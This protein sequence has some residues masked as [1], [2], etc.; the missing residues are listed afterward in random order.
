MG[1]LAHAIDDAKKTL[2]IKTNA[3]LAERLECSDNEISRAKRTSVC[4]DRLL[5][6]LATISGINFQILWLAREIDRAENQDVKSE[7]CKIAQQ[8]CPE[9]FIT[10]KF[11]CAVRQYLNK[12]SK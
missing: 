1:M 3:V 8:V 4:S 11:M 9:F 2:D 10:G 5:R 12:N 6:K 7:I